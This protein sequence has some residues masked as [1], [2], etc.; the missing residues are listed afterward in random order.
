MTRNKGPEPTTQNVVAQ[1]CIVGTRFKGHGQY[2]A[3]R[4]SVQTGLQKLGLPRVNVREA[5]DRAI[6]NGVL[7]ASEDDVYLIVKY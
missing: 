6:T 1:I 3:K 4:S 7:E 5:I 2:F